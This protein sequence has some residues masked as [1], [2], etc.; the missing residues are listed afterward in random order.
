[1]AVSGWLSAP[2][3]ALGLGGHLGAG[4]LSV[5]PVACES[6]SPPCSALGP[7]AGCP[8]AHL[9]CASVR[10]SPGQ[11]RGRRR[12]YIGSRLWPLTLTYQ[13]ELKK[14]VSGLFFFYQPARKQPP[15]RV[16]RKIRAQIHLS[17]IGTGWSEH[18]PTVPPARI[19]QRQRV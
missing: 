16:K 17:Q 1:M 2:E 7:Q 15:N 19:L 3:P 9:T 8:Q 18:S 10:P 11:A 12:Q 14:G 5:Q 6:H 13:P 4:P